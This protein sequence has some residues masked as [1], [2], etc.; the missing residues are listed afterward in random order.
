MFLFS[1]FAKERERAENR[2]TFFK[3]RSR[4][5]IERQVNAYTDWIGRAGKQCPLTTNAGYS[6]LSNMRDIL[7][8]TLNRFKFDD[9]ARENEERK[10]KRNAI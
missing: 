3:Y 9:S 2:R 5:K 10:V 6:V 7:E 8:K 1:E 4:E